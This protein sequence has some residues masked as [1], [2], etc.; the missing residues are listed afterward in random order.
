MDCPGL[1]EQGLGRRSAECP[2][3]CHYDARAHLDLEPLTPPVLS[4]HIHR[5]ELASHVQGHTSF[6][7]AS[8]SYRNGPLIR[9]SGHFTL[10]A[11]VVPPE[12]RDKAKDSSGPL[13]GRKLNNKE[14]TEKLD[15]ERWTQRGD[16]GQ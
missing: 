12:Q 7:L 8:V 4:C 15:G 1:F 13:E 9:L 6:F 5:S 10:G 14:F 11:E 16:A 2:G 3:S